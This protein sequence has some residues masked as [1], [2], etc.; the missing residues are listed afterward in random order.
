[1]GGAGRSRLSPTRRRR[2]R[3]CRAGRDVHARV[4]H[5]LGGSRLELEADA[6]VDVA[7]LRPFSGA[8]GRFGAGELRVNGASLLF[9]GQ[10]GGGGTVFDGPV[11]IEAASENTTYRRRGAAHLGRHRLAARR[12]RP[13]R[14]TVGERGEDEHRQRGRRDVADRRAGELGADRQVRCG[15]FLGSGDVVNSGTVTIAA[16]RFGAGGTLSQCA[17]LTSVSA[18]AI[19]DKDV[20]LD[21][22]VLKGHGYR[23]LGG[24]QRAGR[25]SRAASPGTLTVAGA[26]FQGRGG[27][28]GSRSR[29]PTVFDVLAVAAAGV[30]GRH[31]AAR[32][33]P[34]AGR[35]R[36][37]AHRD[38]RHA[39]WAVE[40][41]HGVAGYA[42]GGLSVCPAARVREPAADT[43]SDSR[44]DAD[45]EPGPAVAAA[46]ARADAVSAAAAH[47]RGP[48][49]VAVGEALRAGVRSASSPGGSDRRPRDREGQQ[50]AREALDAHGRPARLRAGGSR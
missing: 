4:A 7:E 30:P 41:G 9:A 23:A 15:Q 29:A 28:C 2:H 27:R 16:G 49:L 50:Q 8:G 13:R 19:L 22:G 20:V 17:G 12:D 3:A 39:R 14:R 31:A 10:L 43:G 36:P 40:R 45:P 21:G 47:R 1:M 42:A 25:S 46:D 11:L 35:R 44:S 24:E 26:F 18:G 33:R 37:A 48:R 32:R 38:R 5:G 6:E 34:H